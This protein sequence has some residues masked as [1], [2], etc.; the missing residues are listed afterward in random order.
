M[1]KEARLTLQEAFVLPV[2]VRQ[3]GVLQEAVFKAA[4][5][6]TM[7]LSLQVQEVSVTL[8]FLIMEPMLVSGQLAQE[9]HYM[10]QEV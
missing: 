5:L 1:F 10:W 2:I 8:R 4:A 6:L 9:Q 7:L 3:T